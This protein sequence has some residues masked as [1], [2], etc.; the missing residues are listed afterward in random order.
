MMGSSAVQI[1]AAWQACE[2]NH[3]C[4]YSA[5]EDEGPQ[6][7]LNVPG[8]W[9]M[10]TE[11]TNGQYKRC[12]DVGKCTKPG[13]DSWDKPEFSDYPVTDIDWHQ[14]QTFAAWSGG[15]LPNEAQWEKAACGTHGLIYPW[16]NEAPDDQHLN[17]TNKIGHTTMV[18][19]YPLGQSPYGV[20][21]MAG[22]VQEWTSSIYRPYPYKADD[23]REELTGS[24]A[25]SLRGGAFTD[26][27]YMVRCASRNSNHS[28]FRSYYVGFRVVS[29]GS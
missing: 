5:F 23:G 6:Q 21:D 2:V 18:S 22:N 15:R 17:Y 27:N 19:S 1:D 28:D 3:D 9:I 24:D 29:L 14:A 8:F 12:V 25:R 11:V 10:Q 16:G 7:S 20:L 4:N 26:D 13:N